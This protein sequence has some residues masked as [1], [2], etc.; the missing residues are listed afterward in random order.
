MER[1]LGRPSASL[2]RFASRGSLLSRRRNLLYAAAKMCQKAQTE[3]AVDSQ[4]CDTHAWKKELKFLVIFSAIT[5]LPVCDPTAA[6]G[7]L[8]D[9]VHFLRHWNDG[10]E[11]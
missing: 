1:I 7:G 5:C 4:Q 10:A 8:S 11:G 2:L 9:G 6:A 3:T